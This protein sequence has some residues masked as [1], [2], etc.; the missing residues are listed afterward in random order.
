MP[1]PR[2]PLAV[3]D[4]DGTLLQRTPEN[5]LGLQ[6]VFMDALGVNVRRDWGDYRS[7]T[8]SGITHEVCELMMGRRA[9]P[10]EILRVKRSLMSL[11][12]DLRRK[13]GRL[14]E[15]TPGARGV[16]PAMR[17][18]GFG[19]AIATGNWRVSARFKLASAGIGRAGAR[20]ATAD[21]HEVRAGIIR[22]AVMLSGGRRRF[23]GAV[24]VGDRPWDL[25]ASRALGIGF[26]GVGTGRQAR[27]LRRAGARECLAGFRDIDAFIGAVMRECARANRRRRPSGSRRRQ[28]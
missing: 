10:A 27:N 25:R 15:P 23:A 12:R 7:S 20:M 9:T 18:A 1:V 5:P 19:V 6:R 26:V 28:G 3:F 4:I 24:Y 21:D 2:K 22:R 14:Y 13:A 11:L 17:R 8:D 16:I